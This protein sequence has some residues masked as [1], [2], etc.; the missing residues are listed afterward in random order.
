MPTTRRSLRGS[1]TCELRACSLH[2]LGPMRRRTTPRRK[3][4]SFVGTSATPA[5]CT[6]K[7]QQ[8]KRATGGQKP[9]QHRRR[10]RARATRARTKARPSRLGSVMEAKREKESEKKRKNFTC[11]KVVVEESKTIVTP[12]SIELPSIHTALSVC[13]TQT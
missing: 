5:R 6:C 10:R 9:R 2:E 1:R 7:H 13:I 12:H 4:G 3:E 8:H 11:G